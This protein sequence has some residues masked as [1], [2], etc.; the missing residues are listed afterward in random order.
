M[1][2][3]LLNL[4]TPA[5]HHL[6][7]HARNLAQQGE[8]RFA[9]VFAHAATELHTEAEIIRLLRARPDRR[10][11]DLVEPNEREVKCLD[12]SRVYRVYAAL[13]DDYPKGNP[14]LQ[15]P[16]AD[17][18]KQWLA[19]RQDRHDVA[20]KGAQMTREKADLAL[21]VAYKYIT[22]MTAKVE[23]ALTNPQP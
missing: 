22:H 12:N 7:G 6:L 10:L 18:W 9:V 19:S 21:D 23:A 14:E 20:H 3:T 11:A 17:W 5:S 16:A 1:L 4:L 13:T 2:V 8:H 15:R